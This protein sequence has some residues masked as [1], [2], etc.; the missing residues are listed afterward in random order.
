MKQMVEK[1]VVKNDI[2]NMKRKDDFSYAR[3]IRERKAN[4]EGNESSFLYCFVSKKFFVHNW[5]SIKARKTVLKTPLAK[6]LMSSFERQVTQYF[7]EE[8]LENVLEDVFFFFERMASTTFYEVV[9]IEFFN[10]FFL[11][12]EQNLK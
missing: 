2:K 3:W 4:E 6:F 10:N 9:K 12:N 8:N 7:F 5:T 11:T 1:V